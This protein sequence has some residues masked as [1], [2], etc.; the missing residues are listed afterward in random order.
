MSEIKPALTAEEWANFKNVVRD[1]GAFTLVFSCDPPHFI[2]VANETGG[3]LQYTIRVPQ[4]HLSA[5]AALCLHGQ[6][7]GFTRGD[8]GRLRQVADAIAYDPDEDRDLR[9]LADRIEALLPPKEE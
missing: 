7:Y 6:P 4:E 2:D 1:D 5:L 3:I 8:V 9:D